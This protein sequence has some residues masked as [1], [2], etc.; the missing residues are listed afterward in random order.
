MYY[1]SQFFVPSFG[2]S[3]HTIAKY[4]SNN[5]AGM[6][7]FEYGYGTVFLS[8]PHPEYEEDS[9]RDDTTFG[10]ELEDPDSEW[11]FL[12]RISKW[13]VDASSDGPTTTTTTTTPIIGTTTPT[14]TT[15]GPINE[16]ITDTTTIPTSENLDL[17][18]TVGASIGGALV[19][20]VVA[21][22]YRRM[23]V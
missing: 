8:S 11:D 16:T 2:T 23:Q 18:L 3:V 1:A 22:L 5:K 21:I 15:S 12:L 17:P 4:E 19:L 14:T 7:A 6:I 9:D 20:V 10:D 13:L